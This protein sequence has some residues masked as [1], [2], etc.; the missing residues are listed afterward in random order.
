MFADVK[1]RPPGGDWR[2]HPA[3]TRARQGWRRCARQAPAPHPCA[4]RLPPTS[5]AAAVRAHRP[6]GVADFAPAIARLQLRMLPHVVHV[7]DARVRDLRVIEPLARPASAVSPG[8]RIDDDGAQLLARG[9]ALRIAAR[10]A[11]RSPAPGRAALSSQNT[12]HS[13][14]FCSPSMHGLAVAGGERSVRIDRRVAR[15]GARR[16]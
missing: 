12:A 1:S 5:R 6:A 10:S 16:R 14:S 3:S 13:R 15:A 4:A 11:R 8:E 2:P 7:V 9:T